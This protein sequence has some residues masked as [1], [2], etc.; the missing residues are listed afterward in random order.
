MGR[1]SEMGVAKYNVAES[2]ESGAKKP[3]EGSDDD[4][5][6]KII[7]NQS[8]S[9]EDIELLSKYYE[10]KRHDVF[11]VARRPNR[12]QKSVKKVDGKSVETKLPDYE[13]NRIGIPIANEIISKAVSF[14]SGNPV[15]V[16][17]EGKNEAQKEAI[18]KVL[19]DNKEISFNRRM[20]RALFA[21]REVAEVWYTEP[22]GKIRGHL[23]SPMFGDKL[24]PV[25]DRYR[26]M[27]G[28]GFSNSFQDQQGE[29]IEELTYYTREHT[30]VFRKSVDKWQ[31]VRATANPYGKIAVVYTSQEK[32]DYEDVIWSVNRMER[33]VS[34][35]GDAV[36]DTAYPDKVLIGQ[37]EG[38]VH[39][40]GEGSRYKVDRGGDVKVVESQQASALI[41]LDID[42]NEKIAY[43]QTGTPDLSLENLKGLGSGLSG[44]TLRRMLTG[45]VLKVQ[46][47]R[48]YLDE[49]YQ[50]RYNIINHMVSFI[51]GWSADELTI[52][53]EVVPY[54]PVDLDY[55]LDYLRKMEGMMPTRY[56]VGEFKKRIDPSIDV[57]QIMEW[58]QEESEFSYGGSL[59]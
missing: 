47:K 32:A 58:L 2:Q 25:I 12:G 38:V 16:L 33:A 23:V 35:L 21:F 10:V 29:E 54:V 13:V 8:V 14:A 43:G 24:Y 51:N 44:E 40:P 26:K 36:D 48:E 37:V 50:R 7:K 34:N 59:M 3:Y 1:E 53:C 52:S 55:E 57:E 15:D 6:K 11:D 49:H 18:R 39:V 28:F 27:Q 19:H 41:E 30:L 17:F 45:S 22:D 46:E 42:K 31:M 4:F 5:V 9:D 20:C 56:I